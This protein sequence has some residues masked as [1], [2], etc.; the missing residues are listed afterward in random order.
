MQ[1]SALR[2]RS[3]PTNKS[4]ARA[5]C[6][7]TRERSVRAPSNIGV[8]LSTPAASWAPIPAIATLKTTVSA[9]ATARTC[10]GLG[11][12][13]RASL[14][15]LQLSTEHER[16]AV[17]RSQMPLLSPGADGER[18][19]RRVSLLGVRVPCRRHARLRSGRAP[20]SGEAKLLP[21]WGLAR[22]PYPVEKSQTEVWHSFA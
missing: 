15:T 10:S 7:N 18:A 11:R 1:K 21:S 12:S 8:R 19:P 14:K 2:T 4:Y 3:G 16:R 22:R 6:S 5:T 20:C 17:G 13:S 9:S